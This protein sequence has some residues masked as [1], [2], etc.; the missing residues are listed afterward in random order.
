M[1]IKS[2]VTSGVSLPQIKNYLHRFAIWWAKTT[3]LWSYEELLKC[4]IKS[5][6]DSRLGAFATSLLNQSAKVLRNGSSAD[7]AVCIA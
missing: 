4:F 5:C 1:N 6:W 7:L 2:M 3:V